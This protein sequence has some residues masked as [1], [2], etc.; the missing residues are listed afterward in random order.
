MGRLL[1]NYE[2][3]VARFESRVDP[4]MHLHE[5]FKREAVWNMVL[6]EDKDGSWSW[7]L[8][9]A[10]TPARHAWSA[11]SPVPAAL[12]QQRSAAGTAQ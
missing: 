9:L 7:S 3:E 6:A 12:T 5:C 10:K 11:V 4:K 2:D 1:L 8:S